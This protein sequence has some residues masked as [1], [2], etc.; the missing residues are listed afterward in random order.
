MEIKDLT[1]EI[2]RRFSAYEGFVNDVIKN[3]T[4]SAMNR[5]VAATKATAPVGKRRR[6]HYKNSIASRL[7]SNTKLEYVKTWYVKAPDYRLSHLLEDGHALRDGS[8]YQGTQFIQK[9]AVPI[10]EDYYRS[11]EECIKHG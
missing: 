2:A 4:D 6:K 5:L 3:E 11:V 1:A 7:T 10:L 9:S 8:R